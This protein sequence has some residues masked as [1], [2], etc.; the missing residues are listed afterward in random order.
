[1]IA[2][3]GQVDARLDQIAEQVS[4]AARPGPE[5]DDGLG[6]IGATLVLSE[7]LQRTLAAAGAL[8]A[9][10]GGRVSVRRADGAVFT[11]VQGRVTENAAGLEGPPDGTPFSAG[12]ASW[13][14]ET[15]DGLRSGLVV[16]LGKD[17]TGSLSVYSRLAHAFDADQAEVLEEIARVAAPA[18]RN[19]F[20]YLEVQELAAT[21]SRTGLGSALAFEEALPR[22]VSAARR[23]LPP[24]M[25]LIQIDLDDFGRINRDHSQQVGDAVLTE[26]GERVR[27]TIR[28]NDLAFRNSGGADEFFVILPETTRQEAR[29]F[30]ERLAFEMRAQPFA[31][32]E[33]I[34]MSSGLV[35][36]RLDDTAESLLTRSGLLANRAKHLGKNQVV[37]DADGPGSFRE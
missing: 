25:C 3:L 21:D 35:E 13:E 28:A 15:P 26:F 7:V 6:A 36:L 24:T 33:I 22:E 37:S 23:R 11:E 8:R 9:V 27:A 19:A 32:G 31:H 18:V 34:T 4:A 5:R 1:M 20:A 17:H 16:S 2:A 29:A 10:D 14:V 12:L 30:Y